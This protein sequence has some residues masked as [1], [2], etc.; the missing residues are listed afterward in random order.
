MN[1]IT[2]ISDRWR[3]NGSNIPTAY[4]IVI[5][6]RAVNSKSAVYPVYL[7]SASGD[8]ATK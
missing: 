6:E 1:C 2:K 8:I 5:Q 7:S 4:L 3:R